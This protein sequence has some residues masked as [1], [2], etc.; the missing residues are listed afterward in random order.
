MYRASI[1]T[2]QVKHM[3]QFAGYISCIHCGLKLRCDTG[4]TPD[5]RRQYYRDAAK[6]RRL[7]CP[8]GGNL[9]EAGE[10]L[11]AMAALWDAATVE[12]RYEMVTII[13]EPGGLYYDLENKIIAAL[14]PRP[15]FLPLMRLIE[16]FIEYKEATGTLVT[17]RWQRRNRRDSNPRS[18]A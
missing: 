1:R 5:N 4:N 15:A 8:A 7:P 16:G 6:A 14:K 13:L 10:H 3:Y 17:S 9:M 11:S 12:E 2:E 18:S